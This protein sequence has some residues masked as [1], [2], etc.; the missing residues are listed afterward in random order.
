MLHWTAEIFIFHIIDCRWS[1]VNFP[2]V[3]NIRDSETFKVIITAPLWVT[4][5]NDKSCS[6]SCCC[7]SIS[8]RNCFVRLWQASDNGG[9]SRMGGVEEGGERCVWGR[10]WSLIDPWNDSSFQ[11]CFWKSLGVMGDI[12]PPTSPTPEHFV[13][14]PE[15]F[16]LLQ[17]SH[18]LHPLL[19]QKYIVRG[20]GLTREA[21]YFTWLNQHQRNIC[22]LAELNVDQIMINQIPKNLKA[23]T[24]ETEPS[25][26]PYNTELITS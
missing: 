25:L 23:H 24:S 17:L 22:K 4:E 7:L 19:Q 20:L 11:G 2:L 16:Q 1:K 12:K 13:Q 18:L 14:L 6:D 10:H 3:G 21:K 9:V 5:V 26:H 15:Q 8:E